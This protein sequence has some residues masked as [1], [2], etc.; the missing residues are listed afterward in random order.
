MNTT[1]DEL[2]SPGDFLAEWMGNSGVSIEQLSVDTGFSVQG[3]KD[4]LGGGL[5]AEGMADR[6]A[7]VT[8]VPARIWNLYQKGYL[9]K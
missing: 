7:D 8:G 4:F 2:V 9:K 5:L 6:L 3:L 1:N